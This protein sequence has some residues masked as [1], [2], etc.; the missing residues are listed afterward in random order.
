MLDDIVKTYME[1]AL[2]ELTKGIVQSGPF[3][4]M[5]LLREKSWAFGALG[6]MLLGCHEQ[7]LW[8][9]IEEEIKRMAKLPAP[10]IASIGCAEGYYAIGLK[11]RLPHAE[12]WATDTAA[13]ALRLTALAAAKNAVELHTSLDS[14][15]ALKVAPD[16]IVM[17]CEGAEVVYLDPDAFPALLRSRIIVEVHQSQDQDT[18]NI[19]LGRWRVTHDLF[20]I[21]EHGRNPN[22]YPMLCGRSSLYR[23]LAVCENRPCQM[24]WF[25]MR[26]R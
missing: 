15:E 17:D 22:D 25:L 16:L 26:P 24:A 6:P 18:L 9:P 3:K 1:D 14:I 21:Y 23:W 4:G 5:H 11:L 13:G 12:V 7:E 20:L 19:L 10:K 8:I 2:F